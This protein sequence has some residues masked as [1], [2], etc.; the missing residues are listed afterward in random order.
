MFRI[1]FILAYRIFPNSRPWGLIFQPTPVMG[2]K[3]DVGAY[4][5]TPSRDGR[6]LN[7]TWA[8]IGKNTVSCSP[9][10]SESLGFYSNQIF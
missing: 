9:D 6:L 3:C 2:G 10:F 4:F 8:A 5:P 1:F 7:R